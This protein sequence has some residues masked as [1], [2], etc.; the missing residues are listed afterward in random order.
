[1][2]IFVEIKSGIILVFEG[3]IPCQ[4]SGSDYPW[5]LH[6]ITISIPPLVYQISGFAWF[7]LLPG[8][9]G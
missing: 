8:N 9:A 5:L 2:H 3:K 4:I 1:M 7:L 6:H